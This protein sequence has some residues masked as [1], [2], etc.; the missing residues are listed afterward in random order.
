[1]YTIHLAYILKMKVIILI[2]IYK[3]W[4]IRQSKGITVLHRRHNGRILRDEQGKVS[5]E[6]RW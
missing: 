2:G 5:N 3:C 4:E 1:M 6:K